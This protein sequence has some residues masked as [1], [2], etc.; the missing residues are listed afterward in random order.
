MYNEVSKKASLKY[1]KENIKKVPFE[2][3]IEEYE[4]LKEYCESKGYKVATYIKEAAEMKME[5]IDKNAD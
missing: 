4:E 1:Q 3:L 5:K 2:M